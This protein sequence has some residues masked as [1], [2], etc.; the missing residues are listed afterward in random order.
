MAILVTVAVIE[1]VSSGQSAWLTTVIVFFWKFTAAPLI[2]WVLI[3]GALWLFNRL[4]PQDRGLYYLLSLG[5]ILLIYGLTEMM[6]ASGMLAVFV[7]G[8]VMG[9]SPFVYKQGVGNFSSA[10][11]T[12]AN[13]GMFAL[14]G[15]QVFPHQWACALDG[16]TRSSSLGQVS[17][18]RCRSSWPPIRR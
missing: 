12:V 7:A 9:N 3:R 16:G 10:L 4:S 11:S 2:G 17:E 13:I 5:I 15:L 14:L 8:Y 6:N 1:A 18:V